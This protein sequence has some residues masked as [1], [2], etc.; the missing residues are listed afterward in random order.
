M[1][2]TFARSSARFSFKAEMSFRRK[3][4]VRGMGS[5]SIAKSHS[6]NEINVNDVSRESDE[7]LQLIQVTKNSV[8]A[9]VSIRGS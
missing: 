6:A 2:Y 8:N 7:V 9:H 1:Y 5:V 3:A 4:R